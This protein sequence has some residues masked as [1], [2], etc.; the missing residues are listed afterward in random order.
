MTARLT[1]FVAG[2]TAGTRRMVMA[3]RLWCD[4]HLVGRYRLDV[5]DILNWPAQAENLSVLAVPALALE[6]PPALVVGNL[7]DMSRTMA[8]LGLV[9]SGV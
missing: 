9:G 7:C 5:L 2:N 4:T 3:V 8:A 6:S 1:L